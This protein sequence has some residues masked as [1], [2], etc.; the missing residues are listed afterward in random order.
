M[1]DCRVGSALRSAHGVWCG[2]GDRSLKTQGWTFPRCNDIDR[3]SARAWE[4]QQLRANV[5]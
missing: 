5:S 2:G 4:G 3:L 1:G